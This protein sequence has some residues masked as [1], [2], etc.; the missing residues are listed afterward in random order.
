[1]RTLLAL[2]LT[3]SLIPAA[4]GQDA[5]RALIEKA[6]H[7]HGGPALDKYPAGRAK[8][9]GTIVLK[10]A[11]YAFTM[12]RVFQMP[13]KLR[14][15][16]EVVIA[17]V[18]RP[19]T[20]AVYGNTVSASA[21]GL[22]QELPRSQVDELRTAVHVQTIARLTPLLK[23][24]KYKL[25]PAED[26]TFEGKPADGVIVSAEGIKDVRL[27]FDRQ[28]NLLLAIERMGFDDQGKPAEHLDLFS[29]YHEANG[30][31]YPTKTLVK[32]NGKRYLESETIEFKPLE[33]VDSREFQ[34]NPS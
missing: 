20:C 11:E 23:D 13:G 2:A 28:T 9:K 12:E 17:G 26:K 27:Y 7:A 29:D 18:G 33:K 24:K 16:S 19:V 25:A 22:P 5:A 4:R 30:L 31:K 34:I 32:Q 1:M 21:G 8:A 14:I 3:V 15:T 10:G 6:I